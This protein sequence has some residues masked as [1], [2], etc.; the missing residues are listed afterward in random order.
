MATLVPGAN[1]TGP[2]LASLMTRQLDE[3]VGTIQR[4]GETRY[5]NGVPSSVLG[6][7]NDVY[8]D[9]ATGSEYQKAG[10]IWTFKFNKKGA[11]GKTPQ[12]GVDYQNGQDGLDGNEIVDKPYAPGLNDQVGY[13]TG[14]QW[15]HSIS[16]KAYDR[17]TFIDGQWRLVFRKAETSTTPVVSAVTVTGFSPSSAPAGASVTINGSGF[18]GASSVSFNGTP[19]SFTVLNATTISATVP[20]GATT[21]KVLVATASG[22]GQS[23]ANFTVTATP[24]PGNTLPV[25]NAG[26]DVTLTLP[27]NQVALLGTG[28]DADGSITAYAWA[29]VTGPNN[30]T[31]LPASSQNVVASNLIE[32]IYQ[33]RLTVTDD[34]QAT[35]TDDVVVTVNPA[36]PTTPAGNV[37]D[38]S[39]AGMFSQTMYDEARTGYRMR[40]STAVGRTFTTAANTATFRIYSNTGYD[41]GNKARI[42]LLCDGAPFATITAT[43][44]GVSDFVVPLKTDGQ[45]HIYT[46]VEGVAMALTGTT[47]GGT[48]VLGVTLPT[49]AAYTLQPL[50][51]RKANRIA[52]LS[53]SILVGDGTTNPGVTSPVAYLRGLAPSYE[54]AT[55]GFCGRAANTSLASPTDVNEQAQRIADYLAGANLKTLVYQ[56]GAND[57]NAGYSI[58]DFKTAA[59][60]LLDR[61][62]FLDASIRVL[63]ARPYYM[64]GE[65]SKNYD[66]YR[67]ALQEV[68]AA[69]S[70]FVV[71]HDTS[72]VVDGSTASARLADGLHFN[73]TGAYIAAQNLLAGIT[74]QSVPAS[75]GGAP[76]T[77]EPKNLSVNLIG[78]PS[79]DDAGPGWQGYEERLTDDGAWQPLTIRDTVGGR[80]TGSQIASGAT[81]SVRLQST[82]GGDGS[83]SSV[84]F[85]GNING[86]YDETQY[87]LAGGGWTPF[88]GNG[89]YNGSLRYLDMG[90]GYSATT[91]L[92]RFT[93]SFTGFAWV[94]SSQVE[95]AGDVYVD[96]N[97]YGSYLVSVNQFGGLGGV[98]FSITGL[99][100]GQ[101]TIEFRK[102]AG[103][104]LFADRLI[105]L[106]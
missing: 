83:F 96:G 54:V 15:F 29:Q 58:P 68:A 43:S 61:V 66:A 75:G 85:T 57:A 67:T 7:D 52:M 41:G 16:Q 44:A 2:Q 98:A 24:T 87:E 47:F 19:A 22:S 18:T 55:I 30:A 97:F 86:D 39:A 28:T 46:P 72:S 12:L 34:K 76:A 71:Y 95:N 8:T 17:Y 99:T 74:G 33:F 42:A 45:S 60:N 27:T 38:Y 79:W 59:A 13:K 103:K 35:K 94:T 82:S 105:T 26:S 1:V 73:D 77:K 69:R 65:G 106:A 37:I 62:H 63:I 9:T 51:A 92:A 23:T 84:Q 40:S 93:G 101:H 104:F 21:G 56:L 32:G 91:N 88:A 50:P 25:A 64:N 10:G 102:V 49:G 20:V 4:R 36:A 48:Y 3:I 90:V 78:Q 100:L 5:G 89:S 80:L 53:D 70:S 81:Y 6:F 14:D 31:G 11:A